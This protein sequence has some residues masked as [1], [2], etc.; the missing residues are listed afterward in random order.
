MSMLDSKAVVDLCTTHGFAIAG[1]SQA[2]RSVHDVALVQ[3]LASEKHGEM[4]WMH[5]NVDIRLDPRNLVEGAKTVICVADRY[6]ALP[7]KPLG[8]R[9]G[10]IA[11]YARGRDYHKTMKKRLHA[12]CDV[13]RKEFPEEIFR[14]CVDTAP[15]LEREFAQRSG[16][17]AIGKHTLLIE[18]GIG[19]WMLLGA[20][21]TTANC[22]VSSPVAVDPCATC[23]RCIDACPTDAITPWSLDARKCIS[24]LTI[25]H[26]GTIDSSYY[27]KIGRWLFGCDICQE[28]CPH[29]QQSEL[30]SKAEIHPSYKER[31]ESLDVLEVLGWDE[32]ARRKHFKGSSMKRA[33]LG[34]I[35]RNAAIV[36]GNILAESDD[37]ALRGALE[38]IAEDSGED[39]LVREAALVVLSNVAK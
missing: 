3:W 6:G 1:V 15:L 9:S 5:K 37:I 25:E 4:Q 18:Q 35:R 27:P 16:I 38:T 33:K 19:S 13:L 17:G 29:N 2:D 12:I 26:R 31:L 23:T 32:D 36:A 28:V 24:Y 8:N 20:I 39:A 10:A 14:A 7:E 30:S 21:V 11:R 34:M 22:E